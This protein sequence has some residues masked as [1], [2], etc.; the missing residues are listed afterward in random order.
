MEV[1]THAPLRD[2][3]GRLEREVTELRAQVARR[4]DAATREVATSRRQAEDARAEAASLRREVALLA[5]RLERTEHNLMATARGG[6]A[7]AVAQEVQ[8]C[9]QPFPPIVSNGGVQYFDISSLSM[10]A[11]AQGAVLPAG[12]LASGVLAA[13]AAH[14]GAVHQ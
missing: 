9:A 14:Q 1:S 12:V 6:A 8:H 5:A 3:A 10:K 7:D 2:R 4:L 13:H 11:A